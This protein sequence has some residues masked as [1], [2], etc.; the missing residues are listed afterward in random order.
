MK[1]RPV[2]MTDAEWED[3][4]KLGGAAWVRAQIA[5]AIKALRRSTGAG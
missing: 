5:K 3:C 2:R 4:K 1:N